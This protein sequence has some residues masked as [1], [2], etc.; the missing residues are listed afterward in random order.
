MFQS[1]QWGKLFCHARSS[2][3]RLYWRAIT[4]L[5]MHTIA[6]VLL[7]FIYEKYTM[8]NTL[9]NEK[10]NLQLSS[11]HIFSVTV[12]RQVAFDLIAFQNNVII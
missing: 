6:Y 9:M 11:E 12:C 2:I 7:N 3:L 5:H 1:Y 8:E 4:Y 10:T